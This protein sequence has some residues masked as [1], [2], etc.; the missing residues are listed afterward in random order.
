MFP[1]KGSGQQRSG[2][3]K[4]EKKKEEGLARFLSGSDEKKR[5]T[6]V[7]RLAEGRSVSK[8]EDR[9]GEKGAGE[10]ADRAVEGEEDQ[11]HPRSVRH[12][13]VNGEKKSQG[14]QGA[15]EGGVD[16]HLGDPPDPLRGGEL[17]IG[18]RVSKRRGPAA[19]FV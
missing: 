1:Q 4:E 8:E 3:G 2:E 11:S 10:A 13:S 19:R 5:L 12:R 15:E 16:H 17:L 9:G 14:G 18:R 6:P 7:I